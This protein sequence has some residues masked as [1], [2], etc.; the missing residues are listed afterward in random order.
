MQHE[1]SDSLLTSLFGTSLQ[2]TWP[3]KELRKLIC[4][5][6]LI[7]MEGIENRLAS[8]ESHLTAIRL[9]NLENRLAHMESSRVYQSNHNN[10]AVTLPCQEDGKDSDSQT[11]HFLGNGPSPKQPPW[12]QKTQ[13][14]S[15]AKKRRQ[16]RNRIK[17]SPPAQASVLPSMTTSS[18]GNLPNLPPHQLQ[19]VVVHSHPPQQQLYN[20]LSVQMPPL[21]SMAQPVL[22][23]QLYNL[24]QGARNWMGNTPGSSMMWMA[25]GTCKPH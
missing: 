4:I 8:V 21:P 2:T 22:Q 12:P 13:G 5:F 15:A 24:Q 7:N 23:T 18:H 25:G 3:L 10:T 19:P 9:D 11:Q 14:P 1:N 17:S 20:Q 16:R 6:C